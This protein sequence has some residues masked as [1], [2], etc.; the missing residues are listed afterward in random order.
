MIKIAICEDETIFIKKIRKRI[1]NV[2]DEV[3]IHYT[4]NV[5][6]SGEKLLRDFTTGAHYDIALLDIA[7][8]GINGIE[9]AKKL[10]H[11]ISSDKMPLI[12][13]SS[14]GERAK[15]TLPLRAHR[16]LTKP[17]DDEE[18][19]EALLS[20]Y[21]IWKENQG[22]NYTFKNNSKQ[23]PGGLVTIPLKEIIYF[24]TSLNHNIEVNTLAASYTFRRNMKDIVAQLSPVDFLQIHHSYLINAQHIRRIT[25]KEVE[26]DNGK[27]LQISEGKRPEIRKQYSDILKRQEGLWL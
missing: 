27:I 8:G 3:H 1:S 13:I 21:D 18:F 12:Y 6:Q 20:A 23:Q 5:F 24:Q 10:Q 14:Y 11:Y 16:F 26:M 7:L 25:Y 4:C 17:I 2:Y 19:K 15:E 9:L 22:R